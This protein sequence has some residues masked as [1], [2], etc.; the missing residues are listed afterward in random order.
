MHRRKII[1]LLLLLVAGIA[2]LNPLGVR[3]A[4]AHRNGC[5]R[6]H[7]CP[8]DTGSYVCGDL[9]YY[10]YCP[11]KPKSTVPHTYP[12]G[13]DWNSYTG[14]CILSDGSDFCDNL[15]TWLERNGGLPVFGLPRGQ[16]T[17]DEQQDILFHPFERFRVEFHSREPDGSPYVFQLGLMGEERLVQLGR[18]WQNEPRA[19]PKPGC[20]YFAETGHNLCGAFLQYWKAHG[21]EFDGKRGH[22]YEESLALFGFP[23]SEDVSETNGSGFTGTTQWFQRARF[24]YHGK[25]GV[26]LGLLGNE[27]RGQ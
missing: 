13:I 11:N 27:I 6:W 17:Y 23:I 21:R 8:S 3:V 14:G 10:T 18:I 4:E 19:E 16:M 22:S 26:L 24:E 15:V 5:H 12:A 1:V 25:D 7:S 9:G 2:P 20:L